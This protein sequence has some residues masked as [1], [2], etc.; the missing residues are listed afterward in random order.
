MGTIRNGGTAIVMDHFDPELA[1][2]TIEDY[3][4]THAQF[5]PTMFVR[6]LKLPEADR[7]S[8]EVGSLRMVVHA[9]APCPPEVKEEM[10]EWF[11]PIVH[12]YYGGSEGCGFVTISSVESLTHRGSVG[13]ALNCRIRIVGDDGEEASLGDVG[14]VYFDGGARF[15]YRVDSSKTS[16]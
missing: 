16:A 11:G 1:L 13:R 15:A 9:A 6:M 7:L 10:I 14:T 2:Q 8:F 4:I 12:E 3:E 5:V